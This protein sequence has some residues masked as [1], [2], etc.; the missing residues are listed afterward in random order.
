[1]VFFGLTFKVCNKKH[2]NCSCGDN[3]KSSFGLFRIFRSGNTGLYLFSNLSRSLSAYA[4]SIRRI[5]IYQYIFFSVETHF[6]VISRS[7]HVQH[8]FSSSCYLI[9]SRRRRCCATFIT[10]YVSPICIRTR[11][12]MFMY[13]WRN[14]PFARGSFRTDR[15]GFHNKPAVS[16]FTDG[17]NA[18]WRI[19]EIRLRVSDF[20]FSLSAE[21]VPSSSLFFA[22]IFARFMCVY[23]VGEW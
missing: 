6:S 9:V 22:E 16:W 18:R 5:D 14:L 4:L 15:N 2:F 13:M 10:D 8:N 19:F 21:C 1:M 3:Q 23:D 17:A 20:T 7:N 12:D 11:R